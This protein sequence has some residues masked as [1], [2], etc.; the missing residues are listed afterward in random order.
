MQV[1]ADAGEG[2][3]I[4]DPVERRVVERPE[5]RHHRAVPGHL[6]VD[7]VH[8]PAQQEEESPA[9][10]TSHPEASRRGEH[11]RGTNC[12]DGVRTDPVRDQPAGPGAGRRR[13]NGRSSALSGFTLPALRRGTG[14]LSR[15]YSLRHGAKDNGQNP[16]E[17]SDPSVIQTPLSSR[18][19]EA[20]WSAERVHSGYSSTGRL[21]SR[22]IRRSPSH[23]DNGRRGLAG[24]QGLPESGLAR[25]AG[26]SASESRRTGWDAAAGSRSEGGGRWRAD[27]RPRDR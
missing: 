2:G 3:T 25:R 9:G 22:N 6:A 16:L 7:R 26:R 8:D 10:R 15:P 5:P 20:H 27:R 23:P 11:Q 14:S 18:A 24:L 4:A 1:R 12:G 13:K 21:R 17:Q 19:N